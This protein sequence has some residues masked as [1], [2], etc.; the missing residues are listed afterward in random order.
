MRTHDLRSLGSS[1][2][3]LG[4]L[5][6]ASV[7]SREP[8]RV[9]FP[10]PPG[11]SSVAV[12]HK[13]GTLCSHWVESHGVKYSFDV[14]CGSTAV[15]FVETSDPKFR[16]PE[17]IAVGDKLSK[18]LSVVGSTVGVFDESCGVSLR[19]GW[20][21]RSASPST[22]DDCADVLND[23]IERF[24]TEYVERVERKAAE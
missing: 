19:S 2:V 3:L 21:A 7:T 6:C 16:S 20:I 14:Q 4:L 8:S 23:L 24:E 1:L 18:A 9:G 17:G 22:R 13:G 15:V 5:A 11:S 12:V 10:M